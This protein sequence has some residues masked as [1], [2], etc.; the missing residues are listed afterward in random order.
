MAGKKKDPT[1]P[2]TDVE[3]S[4]V[5]KQD[6]T[7]KPVRAKAKR[8]ANPRAR[9]HMSKESV[10]LN[11]DELSKMTELE[12]ANWLAD[13]QWGSHTEMP[14]PHCGTIDTHYFTRSQLRWKCKGCDTRFSVTSKTVFAD[15][16][17]PLTKILRIAFDW[18]SG[19]SGV[20]ALQLRRNWNVKYATIFSLLHKLREGL[21][22]GNNIGA[23]VGVNEMDGMDALGRR[24]YEKRGN[25]SERAKTPDIPAELKKPGVDENGE[26]LPIKFE[27]N[28]RQNPERRLMLVMCQRGVSAGTGSSATRVAIAMR[29]NG[30]SVKAFAQARASAESIMMTDEDPSY[31]AFSKL[32]AQHN[33]VNHSKE[34]SNGKGV[35][36]NQAESLNARAR[37]GLEGIYLNVSQKYLMDYGCEMT[38]RQDVRKLAMHGKLSHLMGKSLWVGPSQWWGNYSHGKHREYEL[39]IEGDRIIRTRGKPKGYRAPLPR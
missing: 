7:K 11:S 17:L 29:E 8:R 14:C 34:Y 1:P 13:A 22:R 16:K 15:R 35:S 5:E 9:F 31:A 4:T 39:L 33:T 20:P 25:P 27:K 28:A 10:G 30:S 24:G 19:A 2:S 6:D 23:L 21:V 26:P 12:A 37:R 38:W 3:V 32:F 18:S 36:N